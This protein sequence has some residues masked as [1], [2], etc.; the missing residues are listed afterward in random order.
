MAT[1][2]EGGKVDQVEV[3]VRR[4]GVAGEFVHA[5]RMAERTARSSGDPEAIDDAV[6]E[7]LRAEKEYRDAIRGEAIARAGRAA[8]RSAALK[9]R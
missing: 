5:A 1:P 8:A 6:Y 7:R 9:A 4:L 3:A 2:K